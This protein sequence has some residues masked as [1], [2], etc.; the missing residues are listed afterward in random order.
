LEMLDAAAY[1][2]AM[3]NAH[4]LVKQRACWIAPT[5]NAN[6]VVRT[7]RAVLGLE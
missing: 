5:N 1:S 2:F 6:G 4:P 7:I 3:A